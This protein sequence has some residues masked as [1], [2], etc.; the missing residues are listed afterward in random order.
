MSELALLLLDCLMNIDR[1]HPV[2]HGAVETF[3]PVIRWDCPIDLS[4]TR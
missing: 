2:V 3:R 1:G 4:I